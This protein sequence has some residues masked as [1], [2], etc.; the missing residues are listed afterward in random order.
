MQKTEN[1]NYRIN[2]LI[3]DDEERIT[4]KLKYHL[5]KTGHRVLTANTPR[6]GF[7]VLEEENI[8]ILLLDV[9]LPGMNGLD[10]LK[11]V[12]ELNP[13]LEVIMISGFGDMDMVIQAMRNGAVDFIR[14]PFQIMD[15]QL[16]I[17][18]VGKFL[19][20]QHELQESKNKE[21]LVSRELES[22]IETELIGESD[23]IKNVLKIALKA[24]NDKDVNVLITGE[25]GTGKEIIARIMHYA[26]TRK[27]RAF[28]PVNSSA[29]PSTL[30][31]S[32]FFGHVKGSFTDAKTDKA[33]CFE[34]AH[35]GTLFLDEIGDMN[36]A[37]QAKLLRAIE[38]GTIKRVGGNRETPV[39]VRII[40]ATNRDINQM[41][42]NQQFR[43]DLFHRIN[44][45]IINIPP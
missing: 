37:L 42:E 5:E 30:I 45:I 33:G 19:K 6:D 7:R 1:N 41:I 20:L 2:I 24:A 43:I 28:V 25:N 4:E 10:I 11:K 13:D 26:G 14:K 17:E 8:D 15:I 32:E 29:I 38:E 36:Y 31:E 22:L 34:L 44:T 12:K 27:K 40:S 23:A 3:L 35:G 16:A 9:I 39:D 21:S 18:R